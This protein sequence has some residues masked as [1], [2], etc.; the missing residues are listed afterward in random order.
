[1]K[2]PLIHDETRRRR[3]CTGRQSA[4][5]ARCRTTVKTRRTENNGDAEWTMVECGKDQ[6]K[7][8]VWKPKA[9]TTRE[10]NLLDAALSALTRWNRDYW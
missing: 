1:M 3:T 2:N 8:R 9:V 4:R 5:E 6:Q 10:L 7:V